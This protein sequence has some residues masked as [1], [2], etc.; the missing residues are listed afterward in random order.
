MLEV[1]FRSDILV[2]IDEASAGSDAGIARRAW[3]EPPRVP[4]PARDDTPAGWERLIRALVKGRHGTPLEGG[5]LSVYVEAPVVVWWEWTRHRFMSQGTPD[6]GFNLESGRYRVLDGEFYVPPAARPLYEPDDFKPMR[7]RLRTA[8][9]VWAEDPRGYADAEHMRRDD[10]LVLEA[11]YRDS[12]SRY[13][14]M[15]ERG[16]AREVARLGL[17]FGIYYAGYVSA[18]P[19]TWLTFFSLRRNSPDAAT[20]T[21]PQWEIEQADVRCEALFAERWPV[22]YKVFCDNGRLAPGS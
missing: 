1:K 13:Q 21:F 6:L 14:R 8:D 12:W 19:R 22:T 18:N 17:G 3:A 16:V 4:L 15:L 5:Y 11:E 20:P 9:E 10:L 7:P 2:T